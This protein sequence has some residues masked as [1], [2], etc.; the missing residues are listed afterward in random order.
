MELHFCKNKV[1][2]YDIDII[3]K[4]DRFCYIPGH[5]KLY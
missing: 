1:T 3:A 5:D 4:F 2:Y